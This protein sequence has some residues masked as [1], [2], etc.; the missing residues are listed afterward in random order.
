VEKKCVKCGATRPETDFHVNN[1]FADGRLSHCKDCDRRYREERRPQTR[2][3]V[4]RWQRRLREE[5]LR[6]YGGSCAC[7]GESRYEFLAIDH[8]E[9]G[10]AQ[11][12]KQIRMPMPRWL[13]KNGFPDGYRVLCHNCNMSL[14]RYGYCPHQRTVETKEHEQ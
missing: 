2:A 3:N 12:R 11:H 6:H 13:K 8:I 5:V 1:K 4:A 10:G 7:C 9:G 14:G